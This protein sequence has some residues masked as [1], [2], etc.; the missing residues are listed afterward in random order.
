MGRLG[1]FLKAL[2]LGGTDDYHDQ[3]MEDHS[4]VSALYRPTAHVAVHAAVLS[5][6]DND[7]RARAAFE[8]LRAHGIEGHH[9]IHI[10]AGAFEGT[11][12][13]PVSMEIAGHRAP[14][15]PG[16]AQVWDRISRDPDCRARLAKLYP[17]EHFASASDERRHLE[18]L[19][20]NAR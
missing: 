4:K 18:G 14:H 5:E 6:I 15:G 12:C 11:V 3:A 17:A 20:T 13:F 9:A 10:L 1:R 7:D 8:A 19:Q 16:L 2:G